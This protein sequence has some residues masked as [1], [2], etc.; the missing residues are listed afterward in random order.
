MAGEFVKTLAIVAKINTSQVATEAR[1]IGAQMDAGIREAAASASASMGAFDQAIDRVKEKA[2]EIE[3]PLSEGLQAL[4]SLGQRSTAEIQAQIEKI[5]AA[6]ETIRNDAS[7]TDRDKDIAFAKTREQVQR[8]EMELKRGIPQAARQGAAGAEAAM[9]GFKNVLRSIW[10]QVAGPLAGIFAIGGS[11]SSY[12]SGASNAGNMAE[13]L[14]V[15]V[16]ELQIWSGAMERAGG[17]ADSLKATIQKLN[18][19][20]KA[21]GD[22][23]GT[24]LSLSEKANTMSKEAFEK[25]AKEL[26]IDEKTIQVLYKGRKALEEHL[27]RQEEL[28]VYSKEDAEISKKFKQAIS[29]LGTAWNSF[30]SFIGR[31]A[32]PI[33]KTLADILTN[34]VVFLRQHTP[35]VVAAISLVGAALGIRLLPPLRDIPKY[36]NNIWKAFMRWAPFIAIVG[37]LA[38]LIDDFVGYLTGAETE[39]GEF[40]AIFGTG[41]EILANL[42]HWWEIIKDTLVVVGEG[43]K[44]ALRYLLDIG[45]SSGLLS[46]LGQTFKGLLQTLKGLFSLDWGVLHEGLANVL[47][48]IWNLLVSTLKGIGTMIGDSVQAALKLLRELVPGF[49]QVLT[50]VTNIIKG[51][52]NLDWSQIASGLG[53]A[54]SGGAEMAITALRKLASIFGSIISAIVETIFGVDIDFAGMFTRAWDGA[55]GILSSIKDWVFGWFSGLFDVDIDLGDLASKVFDAIT[56]IFTGIKDWIVDWFKNLFNGIELPSLGNI[57]GGAADMAKGAVGVAG[58][59]LGGAVNLGK[60]AFSWLSG[61]FGGSDD[62]DIP[63]VNAGGGRIKTGDDPVPPA[64]N[65]AAV[66]SSAMKD[67]MDLEG[68]FDDAEPQASQ[69]GQAVSGVMA[70]TASTVESGFNSAWSS[71]ASVAVSEFQGAATTIQAI[72]SS[73][74][75]NIG[76]SLGGLI[77]GAQA[78]AADGSMVPAFA[79]VRAQNSSVSNVNNSSNVNIGTMN[80]ATRA[81][82]AKGVAQGMSGALQKNRLVQAGQS[83]VNQK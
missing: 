58:N 76:A 38:I 80:V 30:T 59:V 32:V 18:A 6:Y 77:A 48:G 20:G 51:I 54:F 81:T 3:E 73:V 11:I 13:E 31:L 40:W 61:L 17:S 34:I 49:D 29:D 62:E 42:Q 37:I 35:F 41:P 53:D 19:S 70:D 45:K 7:L 71:T 23:F 27:K 28:G 78:M 24:L 74:I 10:S 36:L 67:S 16:E 1:K 14:K 25:K 79:G 56:G 46:A 47:E 5:K 72:F 50:G 33:M 52:S 2:R 82:N 69:A 43:L 21:N 15:D 44:N 75:E 26:E 55:V 64:Q 12:I 66:F 8:L 22:V 9:G 63:P 57:L 65:A 83:G 68:L 39:F 4:H 60:S